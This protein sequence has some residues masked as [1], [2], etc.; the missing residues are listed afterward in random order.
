MIKPNR[1]AFAQMTLTVLTLAHS[2][3][4]EILQVWDY[5]KD[6]IPKIPITKDTSLIMLKRIK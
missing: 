6:K 1:K 3:G 2:P 4:L 5:I